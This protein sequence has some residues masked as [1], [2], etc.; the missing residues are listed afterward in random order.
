M[1]VSVKIHTDYNCLPGVEVVGEENLVVKKEG[2]CFCWEDHGFKLHVPENA[3]PEGVSEYLVNMKASLTG[4]FKLPDGYELVSAVYWVR[5]P[6]NFTKPVKIEIQHC[7]NFCDPSQLCFVRTSCTQNSLPYKF[8]VID[9][10]SFVPD[11][12]YGVL[13]A[14]RFSGHGVAKKVNP[15]ERSCRYR[16]Q[17]YY[18]VKQLPNYWFCRFVVTKD[19]EMCFTVRIF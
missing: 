18:T 17:V 5:T 10:G 14:A 16:A 12:K 4:Q 15:S 3:L 8:K 2:I 13:S 19:L 7:A 6:K 9:G 11:A 1:Y